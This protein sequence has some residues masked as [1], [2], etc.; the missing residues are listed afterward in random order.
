[1]NIGFNE[2]LKPA[3]TYRGEVGSLEGELSGLQ[4]QIATDEKSLKDLVESVA[5]DRVTS[6]IRDRI[7]RNKK[8][9]KELQ[10][11]IRDAR[12]NLEAAEKNDALR[13]AVDDIETIAMRELGL[14][15]KEE[16]EDS[17]VDVETPELLDEI[18]SPIELEG[19]LLLDNMFSLRDQLE[20]A[21]G[22]IESLNAG[23]RDANKSINQSA[24]ILAS[25]KAPVS[26]ILM[27]ERVREQALQDK[28]R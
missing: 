4:S 10:K 18:V 7:S 28:A 21:N 23:I 8:Q 11:T 15:T 1:L 20:I 3:E 2:N 13:L 25:G 6:G 19:R 5:P 24:T 9:V 14:L 12:N 27:A 26:T 16:A 22:Y 17:L